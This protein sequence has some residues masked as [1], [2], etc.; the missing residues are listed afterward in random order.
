MLFSLPSSPAP[1][2]S[3]SARRLASDRTSYAPLTRWNTSFS[4][5]LSCAG[6]PMMTSS[7]MPPAAQ[8]CYVM[9]AHRVVL[10]QLLAVGQPDLGGV[11]PPLDAEHGV[12][13]GGH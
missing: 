2:L 12:K 3:Y 6:P 1:N 11:G 9:R 7:A 5:P 10:E 4:P 13:V 8:C